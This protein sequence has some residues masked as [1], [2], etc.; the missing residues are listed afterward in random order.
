MRVMRPRCHSNLTPARSAWAASRASGPGPLSCVSPFAFAP[1]LAN[2][3]PLSHAVLGFIPANARSYPP[4]G[5]IANPFSDP[6]SHRSTELSRRRGRHEKGAGARISVDPGDVPLFMGPPLRGKRGTSR[7]S[8]RSS[9]RPDASRARA[10]DGGGRRVVTVN[11]I[12]EH[13]PDSP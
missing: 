9:R 7:K 1:F 13:V 3:S 6:E 11:P 2:G 8:R 4:A 10:E 12:P 5:A